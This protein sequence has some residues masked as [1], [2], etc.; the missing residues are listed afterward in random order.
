MLHGCEFLVAYILHWKDIQTISI[1]IK[2]LGFG[3]HV[4]NGAETLPER[5]EV[6]LFIAN[7]LSDPQLERRELIII[8]IHCFVPGDEDASVF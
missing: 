6:K 4:P 3:E 7:E 1:I 5:E 8:Q 2:R